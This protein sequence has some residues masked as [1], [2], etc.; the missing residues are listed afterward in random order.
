M[1][2]LGEPGKLSIT[3]RELSMKRRRE[4]ELS[5]NTHMN[6][7]KNNAVVTLKMNNCSHCSGSL[8]LF[9][10]ETCSHHT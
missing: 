6:T 7:H 1:N 5:M 9:T 2:T 8:F 10:T 4:G 3:Y